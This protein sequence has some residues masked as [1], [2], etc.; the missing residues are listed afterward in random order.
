MIVEKVRL[1]NFLGRYGAGRVLKTFSLLPGEKMEISLKSY[2]RSSETSKKSSSIFDHVEDEATSEFMDSLGAEQSDKQMHSDS[3]DWGVA[4]QVEQGWGSG[5]AKLSAHVAGAMNAAREQFGKSVKNTC[6]KHAGKKSALRDIKVNA[7][8]ESHVET[9]E[10]QSLKRSIENINTGRTL[11]FV[12]RQ[13]NQEFISLLSLV[14]VRVAYAAFFQPL[15]G[16]PRTVTYRE[17]AVAEL[18]SLVDSV[19]QEDRRAEVKTAI[20]NVLENI[21]DQRGRL[22]SLIETAVPQRDSPQGLMPVPELSY[23]RVKPDL[24][25]EWKDGERGPN[26]TTAGILLSATKVVMRTEGVIV[27][28]VLGGGEALDSYSRGLQQATV[29]QKQAEVAQKTAD[30]AYRLLEKKVVED[31]DRLRAAILDKLKPNPAA[32]LTVSMAPGQG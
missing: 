21:A 25:S 17:V 22:V 4:A 15:A 29:N 24:T 30:V 12:F 32:S 1:S 31:G 7:E 11:N 5:S 3:L 2:N 27:D 16:G 14:D 23:R 10:E 20:V 8:S 13:M 18:D 19:I 26:Y 6:E 9:G 28:A